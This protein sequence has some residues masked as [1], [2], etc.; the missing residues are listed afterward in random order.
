MKELSALSGKDLEKLDKKATAELLVFL[1][2]HQEVHLQTTEAQSVLIGELRDEINRLKKEQGRPKVGKAKQGS[3]NHSSEGERKRGKEKKGKKEGKKAK[4]S[5]DKELKCELSEEEREGL[6]S[7]L[8]LLRYEPLIQ[9][10]VELVREN[11]RYLVAIYYSASEGKTYRAKLP[12]AYQG[13]FGPH[14]QSLC[15]VQRIMN[16]PPQP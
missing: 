5:I 3:T 16:Q 15:H 8:R 10:E 13:Y 6:P 7:D 12:K 9:Q 11:T 14:L 2:N 1:L 4:I